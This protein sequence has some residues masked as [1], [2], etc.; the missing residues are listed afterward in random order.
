MVGGKDVSRS[1]VVRDF[2]EL[3]RQIDA[4]SGDGRMP[5]D[6]AARSF[7]VQKADNPS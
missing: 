5:A 7:R 1:S 2:A 3:M 4:I 6:I